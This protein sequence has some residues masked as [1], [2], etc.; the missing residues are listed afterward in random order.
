LDTLFMASISFAQ[1]TSDKIM[2]S[3]AAMM[4]ASGDFLP[5]CA[6]ARLVLVE[7]GHDA[8]AR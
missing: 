7:R 2:T 3:A 5:D 4:L 8:D 1:P 6:R